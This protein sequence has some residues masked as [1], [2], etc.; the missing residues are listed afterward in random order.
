M[1]ESQITLD[2]TVLKKTDPRIREV[3]PVIIS[4]SRA[5]DIPAFYMDWFLERFDSGSL[6]WKNPYRRDNNIEVFFDQTKGAVFWTKDPAAFL[7][8]IDD[9]NRTGLYFYLQ[10]TLNNYEG[11]G[12]EL[13]V[14]PLS[15]RIQAFQDISRLIGRDRIMWRFDPLLLSDLIPLPEL[16]TRIDRLFFYLAPFTRRMIF[17]F[18]DIS[19]YRGVTRNMTRYG[20]D[21]VREFTDEEKI[22]TARFLQECSSRYGLL[23]MACCQTLD[24]SGYGIVPG[25]CVDDRVFRQIATGDT[26]FI[27]WLDHD[28]V[29]DKGQRPRCTCIWSKDIGE[30]STCMHLC[31]YC[32]ANRGDEIVAAR[33]H[34]HQRARGNG[35]PLL[36][37]VPDL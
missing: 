26:E 29:K 6:I 31:R 27:S 15:E 32:Y 4:V 22:H 33:Y 10:V 7:R 3:H 34:L 9:I 14:P 36:S 19:G 5:T 23:V 11:C 17:S 21:A 37:I 16:F 35:L 2:G 25:R 1:S 24:L 12:Y 13:H 8:R 28:A 20:L 30:Y 18:I